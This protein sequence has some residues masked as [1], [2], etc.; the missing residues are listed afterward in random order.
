MCICTG[1][2]EKFSVNRLQVYEGETA[3]KMDRNCTAQALSYLTKK[4]EFYSW[5]RRE[6]KWFLNS[7]V[8]YCDLIIFKIILEDDWLD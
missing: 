7:C 6:E 4:F 3:A 2:S 8:E 5:K 1:V